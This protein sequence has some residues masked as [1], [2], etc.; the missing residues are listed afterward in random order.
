MGIIAVL[1][2][3]K[4]ADKSI[5]IGKR[6]SDRADVEDAEEGGKVA[7]GCLSYGLGP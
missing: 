5:K 1:C 7:Q 6:G 4:F 2:R 3:T